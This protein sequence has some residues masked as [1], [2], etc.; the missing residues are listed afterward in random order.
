MNTFAAIE[1]GY[2]AIARS[3]IDARR[4][5][6]SLSTIELQGYGGEA[7]PLHLRP[8]TLGLEHSLGIERSV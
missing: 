8:S 6:T 4:G 5:A 7:E 1:L 2:V 3:G